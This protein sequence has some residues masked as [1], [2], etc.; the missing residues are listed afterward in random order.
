MPAGYVFYIPFYHTLPQPWRVRLG[1]IYTYRR[2][3]CVARF[4]ELGNAKAS[5]GETSN[6][7]RFSR[8][9]FYIRVHTTAESGELIGKL[10]EY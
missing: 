9:S 2:G 6:R 10:K 4:D 7:Y 1:Y 8:F 5:K 3:V